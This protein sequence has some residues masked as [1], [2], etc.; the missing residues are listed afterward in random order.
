M[1]RFLTP[2][3]AG[4]IVVLTLLTP[5]FAGVRVVVT[6]QTPTFVVARVTVIVGIRTNVLALN[7]LDSIFRTFIVLVVDIFIDIV[8]VAV[9]LL[10]CINLFIL[11]RVF[12]CFIVVIGSHNWFP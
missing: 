6:L 2:A 9:F 5:T 11:N 7:V 8:S 12:E 1:C 3:F 4:V 10:P